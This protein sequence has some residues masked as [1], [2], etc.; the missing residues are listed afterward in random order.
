MKSAIKVHL[1]VID[2]QS[3]AHLKGS[4]AILIENNCLH[5]VK[6]MV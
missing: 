2:Y 3:L 4:Q 6:Y 1:N 5:A